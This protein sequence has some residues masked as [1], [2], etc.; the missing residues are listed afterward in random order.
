MLDELK[1]KDLLIWAMR[2]ADFYGEQGE[3]ELPEDEIA[4]TPVCESF[5]E[6]MRDYVVKSIDD[7][8]LVEFFDWEELDGGDLEKKITEEARAYCYDLNYSEIAEFW[9]TVAIESIKFGVF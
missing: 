3:C 5:A 2:E 4:L 7:G 1:Q 8:A 6:Q 9:A